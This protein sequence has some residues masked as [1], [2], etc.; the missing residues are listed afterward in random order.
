MGGLNT[1]ALSGAL[2]SAAMIGVISQCNLW[3]RDSQR[4]KRSRVHCPGSEVGRCYSPILD[5][6]SLDSRTS[7]RNLGAGAISQSEVCG[8]NRTGLDVFI[9]YA[10]DTGSP[11]INQLVK[12]ASGQIIPSHGSYQDGVGRLRGRINQLMQQRRTGGVLQIYVVR[13]SWV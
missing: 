10:A 7:R 11:D 1:Q 6:R 3:R 8:K 2:K 5:M 12:L 9:A 13:T 4:R